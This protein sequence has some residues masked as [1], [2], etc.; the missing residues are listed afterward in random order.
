MNPAEAALTQKRDTTVKQLSDGW[1]EM[2]KN[3]DGFLDSDE[4]KALAV[5][6]CG[7]DP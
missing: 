1:G 4:V 5:K 3:G 7:G 2:D 6:M